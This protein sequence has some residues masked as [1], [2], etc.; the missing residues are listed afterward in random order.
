MLRAML[1]L[2]VSMYAH[3]NPNDRRSV[4][5]IPR[6]LFRPDGKRARLDP[7]E[8]TYDESILTTYVDGL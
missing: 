6:Q 1:H 4:T 5:W 7:F 3:E 2:F 8:P